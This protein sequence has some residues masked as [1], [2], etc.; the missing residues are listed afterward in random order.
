MGRAAAISFAKE[1]AIVVG[2]DMN[3]AADTETV[4]L[5]QA[6]GGQM[7]SLSPCDLTKE[8][9]CQRLISEITTTYGRLDVLYNNAAMAYF[10]PIESMTSQTWSDTIDQELS[11]VFLL[12]RAAWP[13]LQQ[14]GKS[15]IINVGSVVGLIGFATLPTIAHTAA[16]GAVMAMTR[17]IAVEGRHHGIRANVICPGLIE[18]NQTVFVLRDPSMANPLLEKTMLNRFGKPEDIAPVALFLASDDSSYMTGS[19][20]VVDG[21]MSAW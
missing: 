14:A 2:C 13:L 3:M 19:K 11:L 20:L 4:R 9:E 7:M 15:S 5:V 17:Q 21:G 6:A 18:T 8:L 12:T 16:K 1:G 10:S